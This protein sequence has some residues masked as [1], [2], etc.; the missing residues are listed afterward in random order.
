MINH[1]KCSYISIISRSWGSRS[2]RSRN[3]YYSLYSKTWGIL[4]YRDHYRYILE[5]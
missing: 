5:F 1:C 2:F 4:S 3:G